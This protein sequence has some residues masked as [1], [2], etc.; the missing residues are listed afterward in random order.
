MKENLAPNTTL[1]PIPAVMVSCGS[2]EESNI[3]TIAWTGVL[4]SEPP[5]VYVSIRPTR[6]SY[7][8]IK[9][10][11]EFVINIPDENLVWATDFCGTKSGKE[12]DKFKE[13]KLTK[14]QCKYVSAPS[15]QECPI[16]LECKVKEIK[17]LG[18]HHMFIAEII[19]VNANSEFVEN[20][21][22]NLPK[23]KLLTY[24]GQEYY[25]A[26]KK[27]GDRGICLK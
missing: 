6:H 20:G 10:T 5:L 11:E 25:V 9:Q 19:G 17:E 21:K 13:A 8:I 2:M 16:N 26:D 12:I 4:N 23:A 1:A 22:I 18:T 15:I 7:E 3:I 24:L 27:V 14:E